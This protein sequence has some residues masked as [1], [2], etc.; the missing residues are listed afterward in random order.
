LVAKRESPRIVSGI[1]QRSI[2]GQIFVEALLAENIFRTPDGIKTGQIE[3]FATFRA[4]KRRASDSA[5]GTHF[6]NR[7]KDLYLGLATK[8][9]SP[10]RIL[11]GRVIGDI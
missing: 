11:R 1:R 10:P 5:I 3:W 9:T 7:S 8:R 4:D 6:P 2:S